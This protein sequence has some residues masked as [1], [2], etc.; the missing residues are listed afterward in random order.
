MPVSLPRSRYIFFK[1]T[2]LLKCL[3]KIT[4]KLTFE[5]IYTHHHRLAVSYESAMELCSSDYAK[6]LRVDFESIDA[7]QHRLPVG[8]AGPVELCLNI[9]DFGYTTM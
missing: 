4:T 3:R 5:S 6:S 9:A 8:Y 1:S 2:S 7:H